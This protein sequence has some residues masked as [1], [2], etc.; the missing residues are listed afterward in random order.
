MGVALYVALEQEVP[1]FDAASVCGKR[2]E[3]AQAR[4]DGIAKNGLTP[5]TPSVVALAAAV[6][7]ERSFDRLAELAL[8]LEKAGCTD[9]GVLAHLRSLGPHARG[10]YALDAVLGK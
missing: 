9:R 5:L 8:A 3:K 1:G 7:Q 10:C 2:L 6:Y 4:L